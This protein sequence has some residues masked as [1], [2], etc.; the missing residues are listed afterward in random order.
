MKKLKAKDFVL[1]WVILQIG[2][3]IISGLN[4]AFLVQVQRAIHT[5][6]GSTETVILVSKW[7]PYAMWIPLSFF[8]YYW[9]T[10]RFLISR[11]NRLNPS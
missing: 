3:F 6:G 11:V 4:T 1:S 8:A 10:K 5:A 9:I 2:L 7:L